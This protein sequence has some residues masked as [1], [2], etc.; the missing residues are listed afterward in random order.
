MKA[1]WTGQYG[2]RWP[3]IGSDGDYDPDTGELLYQ[4]H[5]LVIPF[6]IA[7]ETTRDWNKYFSSLIIGLPN[8]L[9]RCKCMEDE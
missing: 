9:V 8:W 2:N 6:P 5:T 4:R 7:T 1:W 3:W